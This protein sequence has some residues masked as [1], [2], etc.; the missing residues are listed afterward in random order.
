[1][2]S[3]RP[4]RFLPIALLGDSRGHDA[5][6]R[7]RAPRAPRG[8]RS[9]EGKEKGLDVQG[10]SCSLADPLPAALHLERGLLNLA[11]GRDGLLDSH[12]ELVTELLTSYHRGRRA[13]CFVCCT[14]R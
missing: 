11:R 5:E 1:M 14:D 4:G 13:P 7:A 8:W 3:V 6:E 12:C 9:Q 10:P 2:T